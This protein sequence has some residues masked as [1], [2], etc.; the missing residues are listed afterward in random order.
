MLLPVLFVEDSP[1]MLLVYE[2]FLHGSPFGPIVARTTRQ[3]R[4]AVH[5]LVVVP[6]E[7]EVLADLH[8]QRRRRPAAL[9]VLERREIGRR[10]FE[11]RRQNL[12]SR[13]LT[14]RP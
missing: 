13:L 7:V 11:R 10:Q 5:F 6:D 3:A 14:L 1:E 9:A 8:D 4:E 2:K 12:Q